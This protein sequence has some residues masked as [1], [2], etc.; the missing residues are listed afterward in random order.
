MNFWDEESLT[1]HQTPSQISR[2]VGLS[3]LSIKDFDQVTKSASIMDEN[4]NIFHTSLEHCNCDDFNLTKLPCTHMYKLANKLKLFKFTK[5]NRREKL[6]ADFSSGYAKD[7]CFAIRPSSF[8]A[9]DILF[10]PYTKINQRKYGKL[11]RY[12]Q[13]GFYNFSEGFVAY[14]NK[15]AYETTWGEALKQLKFSIQIQEV[16]PTVNVAKITY[17]NAI[18]RQMKISYGTVKFDIYVPNKEKFQEKYIST[19]TCTQDKFVEFLKTGILKEEALNM[20]EHFHHD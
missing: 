3:N 17:D 18:V 13:G 9:L 4:K 1:I 19:H 20:T 11:G 8:L 6:I 10:T 14:D 16:T 5:N 15:I 12:T 7:W 2:Q